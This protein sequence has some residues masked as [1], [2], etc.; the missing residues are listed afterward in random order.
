MLFVNNSIRFKR[1]IF[2][3]LL[4]AVYF[5]GNLYAQNGGSIGGTVE[6]LERRG[7]FRRKC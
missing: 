7:N 2:A 3:V 5:A 4:I 1:S 6:R